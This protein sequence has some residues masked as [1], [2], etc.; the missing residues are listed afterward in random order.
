MDLIQ[1]RK[2]P[3]TAG[4]ESKPLSEFRE[5]DFYRLVIYDWPFTGECMNHKGEAPLLAIF[6]RSSDI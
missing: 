3:R 2:Y 5:R 4:R 6:E 1:Q